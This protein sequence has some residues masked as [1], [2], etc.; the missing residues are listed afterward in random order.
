M[1]LKYLRHAS[2]YQSICR[3]RSRDDLSSFHLSSSPFLRIDLHAQKMDLDDEGPPDLVDTNTQPHDVE[4]Q[5]QTQSLVAQMEDTSIS[6]VPLTIITGN[7]L[8]EIPTF[9]SI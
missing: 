5:A 8:A 4:A 7:A 6:K 2:R 1:R 9:P 3:V